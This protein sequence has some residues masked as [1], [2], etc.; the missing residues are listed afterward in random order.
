MAWMWLN[1]SFYAG[2]QYIASE[3]LVRERPS[4][5]KNPI[6][7]PISIETFDKHNGNTPA[8]NDTKVR[9]YVSPKVITLHPD[10]ELLDTGLVFSAMV[11]SKVDSHGY[12]C[13]TVDLG[14][15]ID[16]IQAPKGKLFGSD[17]TGT[18]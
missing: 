4:W 3:I 15:S 12:R 10:E 13:S 8:E 1:S 2:R 6:V 11:N 17:P 18:S 9:K 5:P 7:D 14:S 16:Q